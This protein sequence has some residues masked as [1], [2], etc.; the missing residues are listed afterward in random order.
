MSKFERDQFMKKGDDAGVGID[1]LGRALQGARRDHTIPGYRAGR[2]C[3]SK[4]SRRC[5]EKL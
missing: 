5:S 1:D 2:D 3:P 4:R